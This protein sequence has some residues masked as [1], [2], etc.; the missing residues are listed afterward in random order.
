[1]FKI[2]IFCLIALIKSFLTNISL[3][4]EVDLET[5]DT[6]IFPNLKMD[7]FLFQQI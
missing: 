3:D 4:F 7:N 1:M 6:P 2:L 5:T